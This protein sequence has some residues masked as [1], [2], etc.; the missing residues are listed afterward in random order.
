MAD[1]AAALFRTFDV[2]RAGK[3]STLE[4]QAMLSD[5]GS[6]DEEIHHIISTLTPSRAIRP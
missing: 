6:S 4:L 5:F 1:E 3:L 2:R